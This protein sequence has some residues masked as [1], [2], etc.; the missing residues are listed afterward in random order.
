[1]KLSFVIPCYRSEKTISGVV[2]EIEH[3]VSKIPDIEWEAILVSDHSPDKVFD[4]IRELCKQYPDQII[5][6]ELAKNF[7]QHAA[8]MAGYKVTAGDVV[9]S[10]DDDGQAPIEAIPS[11]LTKLKEGYDVVMGSY[12]EKKQNLYRQLGTQVNDWMADWLLGKSKHL[13]STSFFAVRRF[14]IDEI[15][16]YENSYPYILG[17]ILRSTN[18]VINIPVNHRER[19][20]GQSGYTTYKLLKLWLNGFTAFS[21]KPLRI[22]TFI[23]FICA[24]FGVLFG[25]WIMINKFLNPDILLGYSSIMV[26]LVFIGGM[27]MLMLGLVGEYIG[28]IYICINKSPQYVIKEKIDFT[29]K[30]KNNEQ[31]ENRLQ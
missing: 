29:T 15:L 11:F 8:L 25:G 23:G 28:R 12:A 19:Q 24:F 10:L 26:T 22:A 5:G 30:N 7:G 2:K 20:E 13:Q 17:L 21:V 1:M 16:H 6:V 27:L 9:F 3:V 18:S 31:L 4:V 14:L